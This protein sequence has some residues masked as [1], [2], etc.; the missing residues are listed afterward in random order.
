MAIE[1]VGVA[2]RGLM[3]SGIAQAGRGLCDYSDP[4]NPKPIEL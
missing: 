2:G 3:G 1:K 4:K